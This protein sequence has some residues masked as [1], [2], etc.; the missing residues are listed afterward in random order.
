MYGFRK[1]GGDCEP[2]FTTIDNSV[3]QPVFNVEPGDMY[4]VC[5]KFINSECV[6][7]ASTIVSGE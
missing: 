2:Q 5:V 6:E 3:I 1:A 4:I 7:S